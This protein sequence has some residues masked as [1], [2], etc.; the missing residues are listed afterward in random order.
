MPGTP[1]RSGRTRKS[2]AELKLS[3]NFREDRHADRDGIK[4]AG[5]PVQPE[6]LDP[7]ELWLWNQ[8]VTQ[9]PAGVL[10]QID[11]A[12]LWAMCELWSLYRLA[13][14][15]AKAEPTDKEARV[16]VLG[17]KKAWDSAAARCGLNPTD[18]LRL[19]LPQSE[20][21]GPSKIRSRQ[22]A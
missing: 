1:G 14:V 9:L 15:I 13:L 22:R 19:Q 3:G 20:N 8:V 17:Y 11:T 16:A 10:A 7:D 4:V 6:G 12:H 2:K 5:A 18:R 21:S